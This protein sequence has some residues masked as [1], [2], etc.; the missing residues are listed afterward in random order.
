MVTWFSWRIA[1]MI[2]KNIEPIGLMQAPLSNFAI[3]KGGQK[4]GVSRPFEV[5]FDHSLEFSKL[6]YL[7]WK[8]RVM[9]TCQFEKFW[10][11]T[12]KQVVLSVFLSGA[13]VNQM[14]ST[15]CLSLR[16]FLME[17]RSPY[18]HFKRIGRTFKWTQLC[19]YFW[20]NKPKK[21]QLCLYISFPSYC[22]D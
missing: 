18:P 16:Q 7:I 13:W 3:R 12:Y 22:E 8:R 19:R 4:V 17:T 10:I 6:S 15:F 21:L 11:S 2:D 9:A 14:G 5:T 1:W 20:L